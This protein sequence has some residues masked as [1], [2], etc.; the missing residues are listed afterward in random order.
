MPGKLAIAVVSISGNAFDTLPAPLTATLPNP[1]PP[2][3]TPNASVATP[4]GSFL[5][6][7][8]AFSKEPYLSAKY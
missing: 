6:D 5:K 7:S 3:A 1:A 8:F 4:T 2:A